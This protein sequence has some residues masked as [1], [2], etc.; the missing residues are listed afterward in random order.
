MPRGPRQHAIT[1]RQRDWL[2]YNFKA[3]GITSAEQLAQSIY[4]NMPQDKAL[5]S[6]EHFSSTLSQLKAKRV[7]IDA[8]LAALE[9]QLPGAGQ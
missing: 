4:L 5:R 2:E 3:L 1:E 7:K 8:R 6:N 9:A